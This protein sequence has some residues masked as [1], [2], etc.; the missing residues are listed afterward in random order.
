M[1]AVRAFLDTVGMILVCCLLLTCL[2]ALLSTGASAIVPILL[3][4]ST[5]F[6]CVFLGTVLAFITVTPG[7]K[8]GHG[9]CATRKDRVAQK[10]P[11]FLI[12]RFHV[13]PSELLG[14]VGFILVL[15]PRPR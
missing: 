7:I 10:A 13:A 5:C 15:V 3:G 2:G 6:A 11:P 12:V 9:Q 1:R 14:T 4:G 8:H